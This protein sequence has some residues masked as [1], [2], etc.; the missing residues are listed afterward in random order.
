M[1]RTA[2]RTFAK[3]WQLIEHAE[4]FEIQDAI[5]QHL[6]YVYFD[7]NPGRRERPLSLEWAHD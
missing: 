4:G 1:T 6:A 2:R 7:D 5:G 3:P